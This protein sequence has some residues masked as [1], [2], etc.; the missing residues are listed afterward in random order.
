M[1]TGAKMLTGCSLNREKG[2]KKVHVLCMH[3][4]S[5]C[6]FIYLFSSSSFLCVL[7]RIQCV[8]CES[9]VILV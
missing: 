3:Y 6:L 1:E 2:Y 8:V 7:Y 9:L 4:N 5:F